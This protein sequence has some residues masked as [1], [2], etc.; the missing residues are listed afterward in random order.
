MGKSDELYE[1]LKERGEEKRTKIHPSND[2]YTST[3]GRLLL[4]FEIVNDDGKVICYERS[5][6]ASLY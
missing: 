3:T 1:F 5:G 4:T 2:D 6:T